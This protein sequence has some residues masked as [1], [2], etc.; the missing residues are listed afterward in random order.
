MFLFPWY[1]EQWSILQPHLCH[2]TELQ[3]KMHFQNTSLWYFSTVTYRT[4]G[5]LE[6][7]FWKSAIYFHHFPSPF[8]NCRFLPILYSI[9]PSITPYISSSLPPSP[10]FSSLST[11]QY[12]SLSASSFVLFTFLHLSSSLSPHSSSSSAFWRSCSTSSSHCPTVSHFPV[13]SKKVM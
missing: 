3:S 4:K 11:Y 5:T 6:L 12:F 10:H 2:Q 7:L 8:L 9:Y 13:R 1:E